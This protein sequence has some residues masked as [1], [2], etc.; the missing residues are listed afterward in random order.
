MKRPKAIRTGPCRRSGWAGEQALSALRQEVV[1]LLS[2]ST[3]KADIDKVLD[4]S[5]SLMEVVKQAVQTTLTKTGNTDVQVTFSAEARTKLDAIAASHLKDLLNKGLE[6]RFDGRFERGFR[7]GPKDGDYQV[8]F[9]DADFLVFFQGYLKARTREV[10]LPGG[11]TWGA[12]TRSSLQASI[13]WP[14]IPCRREQ[15]FATRSV[16]ATRRWTGRTASSL[17]DSS[18]STI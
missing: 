1:Y 15:A 17:C 11:L 12:A 9:T 7:I 4:D 2:R 8:S 5:V 18:C 14:T 10:P 16:S 6:V 3:L 13:P